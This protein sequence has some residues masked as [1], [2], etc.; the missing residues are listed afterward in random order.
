MTVCF[1]QAVPLEAIVEGAPAH[2]QDIRRASLVPSDVLDGA[3]E[4]LAFDFVPRRAE[5]NGEADF[6][7]AAR[8]QLQRQVSERE[9]RR[10]A[11]DNRP[12]DDV[13]KF[14]DVAGPSVC[15]ERI[16]KV[17][18]QPLYALAV[19]A[20]EFFDEMLGQRP[21]VVKPMAQRR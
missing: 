10:P 14:A 17:L 9:H 7:S 6:R 19:L 18:L 12:L 5:S 20:V 16:V 4:K 21:Q 1:G 11:Y 2:P 8:S 13:T 3:E 15:S